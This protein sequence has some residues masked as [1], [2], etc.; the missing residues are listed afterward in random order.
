MSSKFKPGDLIQLN[1]YG[2]FI[3]FEQDKRV[4]IVISKSYDL[5][6]P[7]EEYERDVFYI[8]YDILLGDEII[9]MVPEDFM[10]KYIKDEEDNK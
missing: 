4:G 2:L 7:G 5:L 8:V 1:Y 6:P 3:T 10:E 9:R